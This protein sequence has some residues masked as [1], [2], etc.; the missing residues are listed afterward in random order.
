MP[1]LRLF[2]R[3]MPLICLTMALP[4]LSEARPGLVIETPSTHDAGNVERG[5]LVTHSY[6]L[7]NAGT[8][9]VQFTGMQFNVPGLKARVPASIAPGASV[10][11]HLEWDTRIHSGEFIGEA[12]LQ[13]NTPGAEPLRLVLTGTVI[14][15]IEFDPAPAFYISQF[16]GERQTQTIQLL[17]NQERPVT[18]IRAESPET[19]AIIE[20]KPVSEG[21]H[22][23]VAA[24]ASPELPVG[25]HTGSAYLFTNDPDRPRIRLEVNIKVKADL[26]P[27]AESVELGRL[28]PAVLRANPEMLEFIT[29]SVTVESRY[30]KA[31]KLAATVDLDFLEVVAEAGDDDRRLGIELRPKLDQLK[32][33]SYTGTLTVGFAETPETTLRLPVTVV[34]EG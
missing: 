22:F 19:M 15:P 10:E 20:F 34:V 31:S 27:S 1:A 6:R 33:G 2:L 25:I 9:P 13:T 18:L 3:L 32:P 23:E 21:R 16:S 5:R 26:H 29:G 12:L 17:V 28:R 11:L 30:G 8:E 4:V 7:R 24:T 14:S